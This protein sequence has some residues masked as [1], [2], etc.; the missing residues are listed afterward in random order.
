MEG[1]ADDC[2]MEEAADDCRMEEAAIGGPKRP[3][4]RIGTRREGR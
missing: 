2:R 1:V 4:H 3:S